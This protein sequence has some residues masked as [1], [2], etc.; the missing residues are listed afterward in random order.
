[1]A[2]W[3]FGGGRVTRGLAA[4]AFATGLG[5]SG[6][7]KQPMGLDKPGAAVSGESGDGAASESRKPGES[8]T[9]PR[10]AQHQSFADAARQ[11]DNPPEGAERPPDT[12]CTGKTVAKLYAEVARLWDTVQFVNAAGKRVVYSVLLDTDRGPIEIEMRPD[13]APNHVRNF[14]ALAV[15]GYYDGMKF[16]HV[17]HDEPEDKTLPPLELIEAGSTQGNGDPADDSLG[18]WV[19][20]EA[21]KKG[22]A[23]LPHEAGTVGACHGAEEDNSG[24]RFY[25]S[26]GK[27][28]YLDGKFTTFGKVTRGLDVARTIFMQPAIENR[29]DFG[30]GRP[31][32]PTVIRKATV[33]THEAEAVR[34][35]QR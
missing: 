34:E 31:L 12:T 15:A 8:D 28:P 11:G 30:S 19:N 7:D 25:I 24:C 13:I 5:L 20:S 33:R 26:L 16:D 27:A 35:G 10:D 4:V 29:Q 1:M 14:V 17:V 6:C 32:T 9:P 2:L 3:A 22:A 23:K 21:E 18:Y